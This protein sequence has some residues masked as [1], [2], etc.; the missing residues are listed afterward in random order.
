MEQIGER[1]VEEQ[2][3]EFV[4]WAH[5][6]PPPLPQLLHLVRLR[7]W[8]RGGTDLRG[9]SSGLGDLGDLGPLREESKDEWDT[10]ARG[11]ARGHLARDW[12]R[13]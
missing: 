8:E 4:V 2:K 10:S 12:G 7:V 11:T 13:R 9:R 5:S 3:L 6:P 1:E